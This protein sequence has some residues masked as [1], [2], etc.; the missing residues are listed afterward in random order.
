MFF[1]KNF[2]EIRLAVDKTRS[3]DHPMAPIWV[4]VVDNKAGNLT[5]LD[6]RPAT[7]LAFEWKNKP[8]NKGGE[9]KCARIWRSSYLEYLYK[10][11]CTS[12]VPVLCQI[13][14][15]RCCMSVLLSY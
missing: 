14:N 15:D 5:F 10:H 7:D 1:K 13:S 11:E 12:V 8:V 6:G 4:G 3:G 2:S 9:Q